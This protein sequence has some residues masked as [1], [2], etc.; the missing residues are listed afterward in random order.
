ML[1]RSIQGNYCV[2]GNVTTVS[3]ISSEANGT[4]IQ[5][6]VNGT[7]LAGA[8]TTVTNGVW[9]K[10]GLSIAPGSTITATALSPC[11][12]ISIASNAVVVTSTSS[13]ASL[14]LTTNPVFEQASTLT[15]TGVTGTQVQVYIDNYPVGSPV[16]VSGGVW[17]LNEIG[18]AHV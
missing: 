10:S 5:I 15:G 18:R 4:V 6:I 9:S 3:G 14:T 7:P 12:T 11:K 16:T 2:S 8:T 1:F 13:N 17:T